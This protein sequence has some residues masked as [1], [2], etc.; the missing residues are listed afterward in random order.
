MHA[1][2]LEDIVAG[3]TRLSSIT[4]TTLSYRGFNI[5]ELAEGASYE[6]VVYLL[7]Y[8]ILPN[9][10][11]LD[12]FSTRLA[13]NRALPDGLHQLLE[14]IPSTAAPMDTLRTAVSA[15]AIFETQPPDTSHDDSL[16]K[17]V[18]LVAQVPTIVA[19]LQRLRSGQDLIAPPVEQSTARA[20]LMMLNGEEP[21][22]VEVEAMN[23][24]LVLHADHEFNASTFAARVTAATLADMHA[25]V[26][27]AVAALKG[28]LHGGA[29]AAV[30]AMLRD[31]DSGDKAES[32]VLQR[33]ANREKIMGF[34]H[35]VYKHRDPR[36]KWLREMSRQLGMRAGDLK[37][38]EISARIEEIV[39]REKGLFPNVDFYAATV[40]HY[41]DIPADLMTPVFATSR[42]A[43]WTAH[44][45]EQYADNRLIRP[46]ADYVGPA[47][48]HYV[49]ADQ[50][51]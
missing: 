7:F 20:F 39:L 23:K 40:Y 21:A 47:Q 51:N 32:Y 10:A 15:L 48:Q 36:A 29:N 27:S 33:L 12:A 43:G 4:D 16:A 50:R 11:V 6:E 8:G 45:M 9:P 49:P 34:G 30:M 5:D 35:R 26:T 25:A 2:G 13:E 3:T 18:R 31:I 24:V 28:F 14:D 22:D 42:I 38:Y 41:L 37:W 19:T 1:P 46:R 44:V 17:A